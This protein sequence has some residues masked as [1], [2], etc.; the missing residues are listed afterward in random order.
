MENQ[1][2]FKEEISINK[3]EHNMLFLNALFSFEKLNYFRTFLFS[4][5]K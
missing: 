3:K 1:N 4:E 5:I 2:S